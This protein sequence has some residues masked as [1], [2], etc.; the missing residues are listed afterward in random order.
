[1]QS[2]IQVNQEKQQYSSQKH[3]EVSN[4]IVWLTGHVFASL[5]SP[6]ERY[7]YAKCCNNIQTNMF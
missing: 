4:D 2:L 5:N 3:C 6:D 7:L 1:M